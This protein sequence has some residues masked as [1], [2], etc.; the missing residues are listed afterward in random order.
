MSKRVCLSIFRRVDD[1]TQAMSIFRGVDDVTQAMS[2]GV[3]VNVLFAPP[4]PSGNPVSAPDIH[5]YFSDLT[6]NFAVNDCPPCILNSCFEA[7]NVIRVDLSNITNFVVSS[8]GRT[9]H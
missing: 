3:L 8:F 7:T 4:P 6:L 1:V 5:A 9:L 2:K